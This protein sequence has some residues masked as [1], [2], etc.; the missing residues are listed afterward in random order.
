MQLEKDIKSLFAKKGN[1]LFR[2]MYDCTTTTVFAAK[3]VDQ[4]NLTFKNM[5]GK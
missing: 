1:P 2:C 4:F 3:S 5:F